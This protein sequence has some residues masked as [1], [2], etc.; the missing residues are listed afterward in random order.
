MTQT[1]E[2]GYSGA[3]LTAAAVAGALLGAAIT[4]AT[5]DK[6]KPLS[7]EAPIRVKNGSIE[8]EFLTGKEWEPVGSDGK[9]W[10]VKGNHKKTSD[11]YRLLVANSQGTCKLNDVK[12]ATI[13]FTYSNNNKV[14][15]TLDQRKIRVHSDNAMTA[16]G[17]I[18]RYEQPSGTQPSPG[19]IQSIDIMDPGN[20]QNVCTFTAVDPMLWTLLL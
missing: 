7:D 18:L 3:A 2:S 13:R 5:I 6:I 9:D 10:K 15:V 20:T 11:I 1:T 8:L 14:D 16:A 4:V 17:S 19:Y 12:S